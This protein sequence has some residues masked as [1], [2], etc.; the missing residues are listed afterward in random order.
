MDELAGIIKDFLIETAEHL[1]RLDADVLA[2]EENPDDAE[3][4]AS[5]FRAFHTLKGTCAWLGFAQLEALAHSAESLLSALRDS[6]VRFDTEV[7]STLLKASNVVRRALPTIEA[8]HSEGA[9]DVA[10]LRA[11][12]EA[13]IEATSVPEEP[14]DVWQAAYAGEEALSAIADRTV[15][16]D[17]G[18]LDRLMNQ[19]GELVL[20][21][22]QI[23]QGAATGIGHLRT[24]TAELQQTVMKARLQP[25]GAVWSGLPRLAREA[26]R[27]ANKDA[28]LEM[29]GEHTEVDRSLLQAVRDPMSHLVRNAIDH[30]IESQAE[31]VLAG[32]PAHG[33]VTVAAYHKNGQVV[34][35]VSDDGAGMDLPRIKGVAVARKLITSQQASVMTEREL[36]QLVF[37]PGFST[38]QE[39]SH[40]SGRGVGLDVVK[41]HVDS[42]GGSIDIE[43]TRGQG[44]TIRMH[45]PLTLAIVQALTIRCSGLRFA[46]PQTQVVE[47]VRVKADALEHVHDALVLRLRGAL[48][49]L[50][51]LAQLLERP[52]ARA[53]EVVVVI[54]EAARHR[55][56]VIVDGV[57]DVEEI[58]V[59]PLASQLRALAV[60]S[61]TAVMSDGRVA[62]ILDAHG[63]AQKAHVLTPDI[64]SIASPK[65]AP[66]TEAKRYLVALNRDGGQIA[67]PLDQVERLEDLATS[68]IEVVGNREVVQYRGS[69][70]PLIRLRDVLEERRKVPRE[71]TQAADTLAAIV[72][73]SGSRR[74]GIVV[75]RILDV[76]DDQGVVGP[77]TRRGVA[78][79]VVAFGKVAELIDVEQLP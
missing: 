74:I 8:T 79:T 24:I 3:H 36:T 28:K 52:S 17:V 53:E 63:I 25:I 7:A 33:T 43:T 47:L 49:P 39:V 65:R 23:M 19:V 2:L 45:L 57:G 62:L 37:T 22:N 9:V 67:L 6:K 30:G 54:V 40:L 64:E 77:S 1:E 56:G 16:V 73:H 18:V 13:H 42:L 51:D 34:V 46:V 4:L 72:C 10:A 15:R 26:A 41:T 78:G 44:S 29:I 12:L 48:V 5:A 70:L 35:E 69:I 66:V 20:A 58:V 11:E 31:R 27:A 61:G 71:T 38:R 59:K 75:D 68:S 60:Y 32:K 76:M 55:F 50:V 14:V 21:R